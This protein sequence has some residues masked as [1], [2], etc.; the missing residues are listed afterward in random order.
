[1]IKRFVVI[2]LVVVLGVW[3]YGCAA[4]KNETSQGNNQGT[5]Q[6]P[7]SDSSTS[8]STGTPATPVKI[9][10]WQHYHEGRAPVLE[11]LINQFQASHGQITIETEKIPYD[12]Y[13]DKLMTALSSKSGPD[14]FQVPQTMVPELLTKGV[15]A[16]IP[17]N[18]M[19]AS[20]A[21]KHF[22]PWTIEILVHDGKIYGIPT[23]VQTLILFINKDLANEAQLD[24]NNPPNTWRE[25]EEWAVKG[26][27]KDKNGIIQAGLDTRY[28]WAVFNLFLVQ[29]MGDKPVVDFKNK[30]VNYDDADGLKAWEFI[31]EL[32]VDKG[33]DSPNFL[34]GQQKFE[35]K[36]AL[37][38]SS[39][40]A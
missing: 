28:K 17:D 37:Y 11:K 10:H 21:E 5:E 20:Q 4:A 34:T 38:Q 31:K 40:N 9:T 18:V 22:V 12:T 29:A 36:K 27:K 8:Q 32:M 19:T 6:S 14:V 26:T 23:D 7:G 2:L 33:V 39:C 13:F 25:F 1:M 35:Q 3:F 16:P 30:R 15:L 24:L